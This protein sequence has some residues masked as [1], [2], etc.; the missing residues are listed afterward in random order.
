[1]GAEKGSVLTEA[2]L[3]LFLWMVVCAFFLEVCRRPLYE[4]R[5]EWTSFLVAR[6]A[7]VLGV[8]KAQVRIRRKLKADLAHLETE[9]ISV[10]AEMHPGKIE[11]RAFIRFPSF[12][13]FPWRRHR[14]QGFQMVRKCTFSFR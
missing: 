2:L 3:T 14:K 5:A 4:I 12:L 8:R 13:H 10:D 11:G 1:M 6:A 7:L 9:I